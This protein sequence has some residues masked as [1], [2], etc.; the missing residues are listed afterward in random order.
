MFIGLSLLL[1]LTVNAKTKCRPEE[2]PTHGNSILFQTH[3]TFDRN[4]KERNCNNRYDVCFS[5]SYIGPLYVM[6]ETQLPLFIHIFLRIF[7]SKQTKVSVCKSLEA[8]V[9]VLF[10]LLVSVSN[11]DDDPYR[12]NK[13]INFLFVFQLYC[14]CVCVFNVR[15]C[16]KIFVQS[17]IVPCLKWK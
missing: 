8:E 15:K 10:G 7:K 1:L 9:L 3:D 11:D 12:T 13:W 17:I 6:G 4:S 5:F 14:G 16:S 2:L